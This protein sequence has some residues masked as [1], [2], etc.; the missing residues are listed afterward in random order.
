[1]SLPIIQINP[2]NE[3]YLKMLKMGIPVLAVKNN[4]IRDGK[5]INIINSLPDD[6]EKFSSS[7]NKLNFEKNLEKNLIPSPSDLLNM[8]NDLKKSEPILIKKKNDDGFAPSLNDI[9]NR[10]NTLKKI[11]KNIPKKISPVS[12]KNNPNPSLF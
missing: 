11:D 9:K 2:I 4:M 12:H 6:K 1:M 7:L 8:K 5:D 10:K 3:K